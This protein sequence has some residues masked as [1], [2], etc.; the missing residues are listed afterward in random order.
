MENRSESFELEDMRQQIQLLKAKLE[1]E[2]IVSE[3]LSC[4]L[5][6]TRF[7]ILTGRRKPFM[8]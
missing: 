5:R 6:K 4:N 2:T 7:L 3:N 1:K 8:C